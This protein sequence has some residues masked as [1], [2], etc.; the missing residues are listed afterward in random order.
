[1]N[2]CTNQHIIRISLMLIFIFVACDTKKE[3]AAE[4]E[5]LVGKWKLTESA[6]PSDSLFVGSSW[7]E[8]KQGNVFNSSSSFFW[9]ADSLRSAPLSGTWSISFSGGEF[10]GD[11]ETY[12]NINLKVDT[13]KKSWDL[14][15]NSSP[16][17]W[18][19]YNFHTLYIW[20]LIK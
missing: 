9:R 4:E 13:V 6:F 20:T 11:A 10:M 18:N 1:M 3:E 5:R 2:I 14:E 17:S 7:I 8:L 19:D 15:G 16:I 12:E